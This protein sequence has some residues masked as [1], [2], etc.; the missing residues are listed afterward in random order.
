MGAREYHYSVG[1]IVLDE[2][3]GRAVYSGANDSSFSLTVS[4][5]GGRYVSTS[6]ATF[7]NPG[8]EH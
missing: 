8:I 5:D 7:F 2:S 3:S 4:W 6:A 1:V